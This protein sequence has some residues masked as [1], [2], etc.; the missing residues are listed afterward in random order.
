ML[1]MIKPMS[2]KDGPAPEGVAEG[3]AELLKMEEK[4]RKSWTKS[5][6]TIKPSRD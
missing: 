6:D 4:R 2:T 3:L 1:D 5:L